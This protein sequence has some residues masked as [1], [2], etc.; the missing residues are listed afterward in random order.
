MLLPCTKYTMTL[1]NCCR[2]RI[3]GNVSPPCWIYSALIVRLFALLSL[4]NSFPRPMI[5]LLQLSRMKEITS[6][7]RPCGRAELFTTGGAFKQVTSRARLFAPAPRMEAAG[8]RMRPAASPREL[9]PDPTPTESQGSSPPAG[10]RAFPK[11]WQRSDLRDHPQHP[12]AHVF[13]VKPHTIKL[14]LWLAARFIEIV[15]SNSKSTAM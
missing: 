7:Q 2:F 9:L 15:G 14:L 12:P 3:F 1:Q 4:L 13:I 10:P 8:G 5:S 11:R 6:S